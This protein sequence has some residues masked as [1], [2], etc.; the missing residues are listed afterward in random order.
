MEIRT[1]LGKRTKSTFTNEN[2]GFRQK[3]IKT[4][5]NVYEKIMTEAISIGKFSPYG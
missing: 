1:V 2:Q 4:E 3:N 5:A